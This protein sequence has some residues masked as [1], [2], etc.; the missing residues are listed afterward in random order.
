MTKNAAESLR[1]AKLAE[2]Q[3]NECWENSAKLMRRDEYAAA[4]YVEGVVI[5]R[6]VEFPQEHAWLVLDGQIVDPTLPEVDLHY[7]PAHQW[8]G[9]EF[10]QLDFRYNEKPFF[11]HV[12]FMD[13]GVQVEMDKARKQAWDF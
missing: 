4:I 1:A 10:V 6:K 7:F 12:E 5:S 2:A 11:R 13:R 3:P 8:A 9:E